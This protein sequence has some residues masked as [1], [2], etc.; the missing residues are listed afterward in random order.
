MKY[1]RREIAFGGLASCLAVR[2]AAAASKYRDYS[3]CLPDYISRLAELAR[4]RRD[5]TLASLHDRKKVEERQN[6]ARATFQKMIGEF[7]SKTDLN[8]QVERGFDCGTYTIER[9]GYESRPQFFVT[10]DFYLPKGDGPFP[11]VL[12]QM[13]HAP[14]GKAYGSYQRA[15]QSLA[16]LG[17]AVLAFD[18]IGQGERVYYP[19]PGSNHSRLPSVDDEHTLAGKQLLLVGKT[20]SELQLWDAIRSLDVLAGDKRVQRDRLASVGQSGGATLSMMLAAVDARLATIAVMSGN[21]EN[22]ACPGFLSPGSVDDAEQDF[23]GSGPLGFDRFDMLYPFAPKPLLISVSEKDFYGTYS[24]NYIANSRLEFDRLKMVYSTLGSP[25]NLKWSSTPLPHGLSYD[26]R[27]EL[28]N[29]L[30]KHLRGTANKITAEP[31]GQLS[32]E[33][34][35]WATPSG[36]TVRDWHSKTPLQLV[37]EAAKA[38]ADKKADLLELIKVDRW[39]SPSLKV[40]DKVEST[41]GISIS[42]AE[43][44][45][46]R[47]VFSPGWLFEGKRENI[48]RPV[49]LLLDEHG[50]NATWHESGICHSLAMDGYTVLSADVRGSGDL[51]PAYS[52][53]NPAYVGDHESEDAYAWASLILGKPMLGQRVAD[54]LAWHD[55][56]SAKYQRPVAIAAAGKMTTPAVV[57]AAME[58]KCIG[59]YLAGGLTSFASLIEEEEPREPFANWIPG[60]VPSDDLPGLVKRISPRPIKRGAWSA[61]LIAESFSAAL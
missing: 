53:G 59:I 42:A 13:G 45:T 52:A 20:C 3:R 49:I 2:Y 19:R 12:F 32:P 30:E 58:A 9:V 21:T 38:R 47:E 35:L 10:A 11:G 41:G 4:A 6:W 50:R 33:R 60:S 57:A 31:A 24:P 46:A 39:P 48:G 5:K 29:W 23:V 51:R 37:Q 26:S 18:P 17:F 16:Q 8:L 36:S 55:A 61:S 28:Y 7:P 56:L 15:C 25:E 27:L 34:K 54:I 1:T 22:F 40:L 44:Q 14:D 43:V